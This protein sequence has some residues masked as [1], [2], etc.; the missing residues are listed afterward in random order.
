MTITKTKTGKYFCSI[1]FGYEAEAPKPVVPTPERTVGLN[2]SMAR[3]YVVSNGGRPALPP[4][5]AAGPEKLAR[6]QG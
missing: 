2:Y 4:Q 5:M 3:F 6:M 1:T